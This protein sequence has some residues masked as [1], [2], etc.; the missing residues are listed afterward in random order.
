MS[1]ITVDMN[2][3]KIYCYLK[4]KKK[5]TNLSYC[6]PTMHLPQRA[7]SRLTLSLWLSTCPLSSSSSTEEIIRFTLWTSEVVYHSTKKFLL[8]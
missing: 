3:K 1:Q 7:I 2:D 5:K 8:V 4:K 6:V